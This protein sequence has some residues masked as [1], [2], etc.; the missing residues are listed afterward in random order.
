MLDMPWDLDGLPFVALAHMHD[1]PS[2]AAIYFVRTAKQA[3]YIGATNNLYQR[4]CINH[5]HRFQDFKAI[6]Q[7]IEI[8]WMPFPKTKGARL[9]LYEKAAIALYTPLLN[10]Q[11]NGYHITLSS[12]DTTSS[13]QPIGISKNHLYDIAVS[14]PHNIQTPSNEWRAYVHVYRGLPGRDCIHHVV[15]S[16]GPMAKQ[17]AIAACRMHPDPVALTPV[18]TAEE[19][20]P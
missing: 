8:A 3:L 13:D 1:L 20:K 11:I 14:R 10:S 4:W 9:A 12:T 15:A 5:H 7:A 18:A 16:N 17:I 6:R 19:G 2:C